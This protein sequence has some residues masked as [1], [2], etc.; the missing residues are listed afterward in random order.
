MSEKHAEKIKSNFDYNGK[1]FSNTPSMI[2]PSGRNIKEK[3]ILTKKEK[4]VIGMA[5]SRIS[6]FKG[7][8]L[9]IKALALLSSKYNLILELVGEE[10]NNYF[11]LLI[12][13]LNLRENVIFLGLLTPGE[14]N[15]F[16][17][18]IDIFIV[19][20]KWEGLSTVMLEAMSF[21]I[22]VIS[23][24]VGEIPNFIKDGHNGL[25]FENGNYKGLA[26]KIDLLIQNEGLYRNLSINSID[27]SRNF[28]YENIVEKMIKNYKKV[29]R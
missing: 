18:Q 12:K 16:Y 28:Y 10:I 5:A 4:I 21:G 20:S 26:Q 8:D 1:I 25:F 17:R 15:N 6:T 13:D 9:T 2:I 3:F 14:M 11:R 29:L 23:T 22:P 7:F 19:A 24:K 27:F